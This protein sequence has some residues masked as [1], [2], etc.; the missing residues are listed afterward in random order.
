MLIFV[1]LERHGKCP[2]NRI[3]VMLGKLMLHIQ[4]LT[5]P[6]LERK[7]KTNTERSLIL[8]HYLSCFTAK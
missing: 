1:R 2:L 8:A 7:K 5:R 6:T 4:S 3:V